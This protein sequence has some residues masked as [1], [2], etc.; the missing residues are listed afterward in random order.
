[1]DKSGAQDYLQEALST[2]LG[3]PIKVIGASRTDTGVHAEHQ[4]AIFDTED[5]INEERLLNSLNALTP[6]A[7]SIS[8][9]VKAEPTFHPIYSSK[10]K[11]Y[12]YRIWNSLTPYVFVDPF[13][14]HIRSPLDLKKVK[15]AL[16]FLI[17]TH[18]FSSFCAAD[19]GAKTTVRTLFDVHVEKRG[20]LI[21]IWIIGEGF[22][23]QMVRTIIGTAVMVG[24]GKIEPCDMHK[25]LQKK[26]RTKAGM[27]APAQGLALV[28]IFFDDIASVDSLIQQSQ[29]GI[30]FAL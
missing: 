28:K 29:Q 27:T 30:C 6:K 23:K 2:V 26:D 8:S 25:I 11:A 7:L 18:D 16:Q 1:M 20:N 5:P 12:R 9:L 21:E 14:W 19:S 3:R 22:L 13:A 24:H 10:G 4:V 15:E 17:G